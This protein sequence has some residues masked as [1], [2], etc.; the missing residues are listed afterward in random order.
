MNSGSDTICWRQIIG[1]GAE[2]SIS[3]ALPKLGRLGIHIGLL[4]WFSREAYSI[5]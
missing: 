3:L 1:F 2:F 4:T 5:S